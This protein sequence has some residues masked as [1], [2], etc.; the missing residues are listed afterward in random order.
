MFSLANDMSDLINRNALIRSVDCQSC[1][2]SSIYGKF[3]PQ[4]EI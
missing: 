2:G 3:F 4:I 1:V